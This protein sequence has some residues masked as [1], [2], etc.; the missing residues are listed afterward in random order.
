MLNGQCNNIWYGSTFPDAPK[1]FDNNSSF[2]KL[3]RSGQTV[4]LLTGEDATPATGESNECP[5]K[6]R[7]PD[8][9]KKGAACQLA[10]WGGKLVLTNGPK[11]CPDQAWPR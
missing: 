3:W 5:Q 6:E 1:V 10:K 4:F 11:P 9:V 2:E 8:Y 7:L